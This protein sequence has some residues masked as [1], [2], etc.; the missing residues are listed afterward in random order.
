MS[1]TTLVVGTGVIVAAGRVVSGKG[2]SIDVV[3]G[4]A[5]LA[6]SLA[7]L[8]DILA[9]RFALMV[10]IIA[11]FAYGPAIAHSTGLDKKAKAK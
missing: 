5:A 4:G 3:V 2:M 6:I 1:T 7:F 9:E 11:L 8:P 10:F